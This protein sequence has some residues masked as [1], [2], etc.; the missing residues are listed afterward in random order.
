[1]EPFCA[2][3]GAPPCAATVS[4][5]VTLGGLASAP[6]MEADL[7]AEDVR[8]D[9]VEYGTLSLTARYAART[10]TLHAALRHPQAGTLALDGD[11]PIDLAWQGA[12]RDTAAMPV[13]LTLRAERL[14][15][16]FLRTFAPGQIRQCGG[17]LSVD[18]RLRGPRA[19]LIAEGTVALDEGRLELA[20]AGVPYE[21]IRLR[22][23]AEGRTLRV[24]ELSA[25][26]GDG[27]IAG[28]GTLG[29][30]TSVPLALG[31]TLRLQDF[32]AVRLAAYEA[33]VSGTLDV[34]GSV[35][36]PEV[37]GELEIVRAVVRPAALPQSGPNLEPDPTITVVN[38]PDDVGPPPPPPPPPVFESASLALH[39]VIA[40]NAWIR[41]NDANIELGGD[42]RL[43][44]QP[45]SPVV[46]TGRILLLRGW[47][48]FQGRRFDIDKGTI[49]FTGTTPP[50]PTFDVTAVYKT[51]LYRIEAHIEGT[52]EK[53]R[54]TLS[55]DPPLEQADI[56]AVI[57]FGK[58]THELGKGQSTDLQRQALGLATGY[59]MP[60]LRTSVMNTLGLDALEVELP[61]GTDSPGRVSVGRYVAGDIFVSLAQEFGSRTAEVVSV[62][63]GVTPNISVRGSTS[64]RGESAVDLFWHRRY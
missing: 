61:Q 54:L 31:L 47:Y 22:L 36:A 12:R 64:S 57:L 59:V 32:F 39:V 16:T 50:K 62:E 43:A 33:V 21:D 20:A 58:P 48:A 25:R 29:V 1:M 41:R 9:S 37:A 40:R 15:L 14:D 53:P 46:V 24:T 44:K 26:A 28:E 19:A 55:S 3:F 34:R 38:S 13:D 8:V 60:E 18:L 63:Y 35:A 56:L 2:L 7:T 27:T 42:L 6:S 4:G 51:R 17:R 11:V 23:N 5:R 49:T 52:G 45:F 30:S 10:A